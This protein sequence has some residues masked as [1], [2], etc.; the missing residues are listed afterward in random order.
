MSNLDQLLLNF[1]NLTENI[2]YLGVP[3]HN[4]GIFKKYNLSQVHCIDCIGNLEDTN[5]TKISE[6]LNMTR[7]AISKITKKLLSEGLIKQYKKPDNKKEIFFELTDRGWEV[8]HAHRELHDISE[9]E[10]INIFKKFN[11]NEIE[12]IISFLKEMNN[13]FKE[14]IEEISK[15]EN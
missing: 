6:E 1:K 15:N 13:Y 3:D 2:D 9:I 14:Q 10:Y 5:V 8:Y 7:G 4:R 12:I 11:D